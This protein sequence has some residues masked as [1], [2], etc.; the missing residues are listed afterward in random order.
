M[1]RRPWCW[2][3]MLPLL[4]GCGA[5]AGLYAASQT[6]SIKAFGKGRDAVA[7]VKGY[8]APLARRNADLIAYKYQLMAESPFAFFRG[9][10]A[11]FYSDVAQ[12]ASL[13]SRAR[14]PLQGD[15][16]LENLGTYQT[17]NGAIAYDLNDF[18]EAFT[19]PVTWELARCAVS[20][21]LAADEAGIGDH[22]AGDLV[23]DF[24]QEYRQQ[25][26]R[27][28]GHPAALSEPLTTADGPVGDV[29]KDAARQSRA[30]FIDKLTSHGAFK[31]GKKLSACSPSVRQ[32]VIQAIASYA[33]HRPEGGAYFQVKDVAQR[34]AGVASIGRYRYAALI[35][36]RSRSA[37]DDVVLELK[38][39][40]P[41]AASAVAGTRAAN[42][43]SRVLEAYSYFL[44]RPDALLGTARIQGLDFL[45]RELQPAKAGVE[46]AELKGKKDFG[47]FLETVALVTARAHA[48]ASQSAALLAEVE[49]EPAFVSKIGAFAKAY[50]AQVQ[51]DH[52]AFKTAL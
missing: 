31:L 14:L 44:P 10:A 19:G 26:K 30:D 9:S 35:E 23:A 40:G 5:P 22:D 52:H 45:V 27:L 21:R 39:E 37:D 6:Q 28:A 2:L 33:S 11:L 3:V 36:G 4:V 47:R 20:I 41:S 18:D 46:L 16:H 15:L 48:R 24:L 42:E 13:Q 50:Q 43:A 34:L 49:D 8:Y 29:L 1:K 25:V 38:E 12:V 32:D 17:E 51:T 7:A